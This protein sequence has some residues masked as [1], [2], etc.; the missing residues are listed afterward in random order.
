M[1]LV[2]LAALAAVSVLAA[3]NAHSVKLQR[4]TD[5]HVDRTVTEM[6]SGDIRT[7]AQDGD[8]ILSRSYYLSGDVIATFTS[9]EDL[10]H[11][12]L[13]SATTGTVIES[14]SSGVREIPL[15]DFVHRNHHLILVRPSRLTAADRAESVQIAR[16]K[17]GY[18][19]DARGMFGLDNPDAFYC[20]ELVYWA[21]RVEDRYGD[22]QAVI[23]PSELM[24]YG[25][26]V[27]WSGERTD[28]QIEHAAA[29]H[30]ADRDE[31]AQ[32]AEARFGKKKTVA[33]R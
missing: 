16:A 5:V 11:A 14:V 22:S 30:V 28:P 13:Y 10:S 23:T 4:P 1:Q 33:A 18:P 8:W 29:G 20:T 24:Q 9:G 6:W 21:A 17:V 7:I 25:E 15:E 31:V 2:R 26:V 3:C 19:F 32:R 27:Y 12:S